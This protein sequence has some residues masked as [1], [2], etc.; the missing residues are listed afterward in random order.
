[1]KTWNCIFWRINP[2]LTNGGYE[3][4]RKI[5]ARTASSAEKKATKKYGNCIY[6][7]MS[8]IRVELA[9]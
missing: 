9:D 6:G 7:G 5:E 3:T 8:L 4:V 1:M 2:Q